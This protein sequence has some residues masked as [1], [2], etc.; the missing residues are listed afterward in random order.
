[1]ALPV[2]IPATWAELLAEEIAADWFQKLVN[3]VDIERKQHTV[4]PPEEAVFRALELV[5]PCSVRVTILGQDPYHNPGQAHGLSFSVND[6]VRLPPSLVNI[7]NELQSDLGVAHQDSGN[8]TPWARQGVLLLNS[9]LTVRAHEPNSHRD[10]GWEQLTDRIIEVVSANNPD[11]V[12]MLW[13]SS[14]RQKSRLVG[15]KTHTIIES[16]HPSPLSAYR[17]FV[18]SRPFSRANQALKSSGQTTVDWAL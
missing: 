2:P 5:D 17:G 14:A 12:F 13:G 7:F 10:F 11:S 8:L 15:G 3:K 4:Y 6:G 1:M 18:G 9:V 16:A